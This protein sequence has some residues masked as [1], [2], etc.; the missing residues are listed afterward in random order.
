MGA[1][2]GGGGGGGSMVHLEVPAPFDRSRSRLSVISSSISNLNQT[3]QGHVK[4]KEELLGTVLA[5]ISGT[6]FAGYSKLVK[7]LKED[8]AKDTILLVRGVMQT[9]IA[10]TSMGCQGLSPKAISSG[11][12][13][14]NTNASG[15]RTLRQWLEEKRSC[16]LLFITLGLGSFRLKLLF[17][18]F[19]SI[20]IYRAHAIINSAPVFVMLLSHFLMNDKYNVHKGLVTIGFLGGL[21]TMFQPWQMISEPEQMIAFNST[22]MN[23]FIESFDEGAFNFSSTANFSERAVNFSSSA[24]FTEI[25]EDTNDLPNVP[26]EYAGYACAFVAAVL[27]AMGQILNKKL[28]THFHKEAIFMYL[29][30]AIIAISNGS[31][32]ANYCN[33]AETAPVFPVDLPWTEAISLWSNVFF[34][35]FMGCAQQYCLICK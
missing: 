1:A 19:S 32:I 6:L 27:S 8:I 14:Q 34:V 9:G 23:D 4:G 10:G 30:L 5:L 26:W 7:G 17:N 13:E 31:L 29:G 22:E 21:L 12:E 20:P 11:G 2:I 18:A 24:N 16:I 35:A 28:T 3:L 33:G 25:V 15:N